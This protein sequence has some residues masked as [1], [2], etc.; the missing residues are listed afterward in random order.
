MY[1]GIYFKREILTFSIEEFSEEN[2]P[3]TTSLIENYL[4]LT[5]SAMQMQFHPNTGAD[6]GRKK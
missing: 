6:Y 4:P 2:S 3:P 1:H 5:F